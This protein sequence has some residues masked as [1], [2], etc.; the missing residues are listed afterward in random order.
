MKTNGV[1]ER[2]GVACIILFMAEVLL[3]VLSWL[4]S[5]MRL[6]GVRSLLSGE[7]IRWFLGSFS[8]I[9]GSPP[10]VWLLLLFSSFGCLQKSGVLSFRRNYRDRIA[11]RVSAF[12]FMA[13]VVVIALLTLA[14]HAILLSAT[15]ELFP[16]AFS[17]SIIPLLAFGISLFGIAFGMMA[18]RMN[19]AGAI[20]Y[21][22]SFGVSKGAPFLIIYILLMQFYASLHFVFG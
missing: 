18:G 11:L 9:T 1:Q 5:A 4:L 2:L 19:T 7:G 6:D 13:Y 8:E 10:L 20:L 14:P 22:L 21:A 16:S 12:L 15:G 3:V 17:R